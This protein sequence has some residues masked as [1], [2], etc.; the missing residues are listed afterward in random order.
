MAFMTSQ[1]LRDDDPASQV[2][3]SIKRQGRVTELSGSA[4]HAPRWLQIVRSVTDVAE[5][6]TL[7]DACRRRA[8]AMLESYNG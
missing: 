4:D 1:T 3:T 2:K 6:E 7:R 5:R 8:G